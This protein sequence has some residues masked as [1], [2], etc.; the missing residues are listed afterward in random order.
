[1]RRN[2]SI[3]R[4]LDSWNAP[5]DPKD[6]LPNSS[7]TSSAC[8][9]LRMTACGTVIRRLRR[10][11]I[12]IW[13]EFITL[14]LEM[15]VGQYSVLQPTGQSK[16]S[17]TVGGISYWRGGSNWRSWSSVAMARRIDITYAQC[18][19]SVQPGFSVLT[20]MKSNVEYSLIVCT[21]RHMDLVYQDLLG[22][23]SSVEAP[24]ERVGTLDAL[25]ILFFDPIFNAF[26]LS[27]FSGSKNTSISD[28][29]RYPRRLEWQALWWARKLLQA[30]HHV[31]VVVTFIRIATLLLSG[32]SSA[33]KL[34]RY[35][36]S[37]IWS[38]H[39]VSSLS[40]A[41]GYGT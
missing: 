13:K 32:R 33:I 36:V 31:W 15:D 7:S 37:T 6:T 28:S 30:G 17:D 20:I 1:M 3:R 14:F 25:G 4:Y 27:P 41:Q 40:R 29:I 18:N 8:I 2:C 11:N 16:Q 35:R 12:D 19:F 38:P 39:S 10:G 21:C 5:L 26:M 9:A 23:T 24:T 34:A 22:P